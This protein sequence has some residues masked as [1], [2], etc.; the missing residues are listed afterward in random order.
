MIISAKY[1]D[2]FQELLHHPVVLR[3][4]I[5]DV[6]GIPQHK[7]RSVRLKNTLLWKRHRKE[8]LGILD[9][10]A[11]LNNDTKIDI[12]L[13]VRV[14]D[15][16]D[17]RQLFYLAKLFTEDLN[18]GQDYSLLKKCVGIS[19]LD[20]NLTDREKYHTVYRLRD[21][22]GNEF[23]D[24]LEL[25]VIELRK[26]LTG[27]GDMD[28]WI[29]LFNAKKKEDLD[30]IKTNN[31]GIL[32]AIGILQKMSLNNPLRV[33]YEAYLKKV[34]DE[35]AWRIHVWK[36]ATSKGWTAGRTA[37]HAEGHAEGRAEGIALGKTEGIALGKTE[38]IALG[39]TEGIALGKAESILDLLSEHGEVSEELKT[40]IL[41]E[42]DVKQL[43]Q[44]LKFAAACQSADDFQEKA[45]LT[46]LQESRRTS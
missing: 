43:Q 17:K 27:Q 4:F 19:I 6:L 44:W 32:T 22:E 2:V 31:P 10:A 14:Y 42:K 12:E 16:W 46:F 38:G 34:R 23:S 26:A 15:S 41:S 20:F 1:D 18:T 13:Q 21:K 40:R 29:R 39:K 9:V 30:M 11:E 24:V 45:N 28:D 25:H 36:E 33:R 3:Y 37:G 7:I 35:R 8:K 5:G